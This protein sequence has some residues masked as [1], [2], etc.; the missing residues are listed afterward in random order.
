MQTALLNHRPSPAHARPRI[1]A[2]L[3]GRLVV[4]A[5][6]RADLRDRLAATGSTPRW[7]EEARVW[8]LPRK[9][10]QAV[11]A[12]VL[13]AYGRVGVTIEAQGREHDTTWITY[14]LDR[15]DG[16]SL[17]KWPD[18]VDLASPALQRA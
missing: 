3:S 13:G 18:V 1:T 17:K 6:F 14:D 4:R 2:P 16:E 12:E 7:D 15:A 9:T 5:P 8:T 10:L 11:V